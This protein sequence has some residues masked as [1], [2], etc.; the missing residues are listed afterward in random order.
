MAQDVADDVAK[1]YYDRTLHGVDWDGKLRETREK[2][3]KAKSSNLAFANIAAMLD[4]LGDSHTFFI[5][6]RRSFLLDYGWRIQMIGERCLVTGVRPETDAAT[7]VRPGDEVL[8][9]NDD[10]PARGNLVRI[11][12]VLNVLRPQNKI[13]ATIRSVGG[14]ERQIEIIPKTFG[15][16]ANPWLFR[17]EEHKRR[18]P[19]IVSIDDDVLVVKILEFRFD[20]EEVNKLLD[21]ARKHKWVIL[22]LRGNPGGSE[23]SLRLLVSKFFD[24]EVKIADAVS[25]NG[26]K[27]RIAKP[28]H[29]A[30]SGKL[31][32]LVDSSSSSAAELFARVVQ[33]EKRGIVIGDH[34][35]GMVMEAEQHR[36]AH[37]GIPFAASVTIANLIMSDGKSLEHVGVIPDELALPTVE[38]LA[39]HRDPVLAHAAEI[40]G[41]RLSPEDAAQL[42][43]YQWPEPS[44]LAGQ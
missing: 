20:E 30:F 32:V 42:L 11:E 35:A 41:A 17:E 28:D 14:E 43:P 44:P 2:I 25:R 26:T 3:Q 29:R 13:E 39:N 24:H 10:R 15:L 1:H 27:P 40:A 34:T 16:P 23:E 19:H 36:L 7:K 9:V 37:D 8:A 6:P 5:P 21:E 38:D 18:Q 31:T 12:Y 22:D 4:S 33:L